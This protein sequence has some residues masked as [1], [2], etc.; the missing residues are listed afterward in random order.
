MLKS[1]KNTLILALSLSLTQV[2]TPNSF[3][4]TKSNETMPGLNISAE[5]LAE[6]K[7]DPKKAESELQTLKNLIPLFQNHIETTKAEL[8]K[9][10]EDHEKQFGKQEADRN[11]KAYISA[12]VFSTLMMSSTFLAIRSS[13]YSYKAYEFDKEYFRAYYENVIQDPELF[14][15]YGAEKLVNLAKQQPIDKM[16]KDFPELADALSKIK[17]FEKATN[18]S[19]LLWVISFI[20]TFHYLSSSETS[21]INLSHTK[22]NKLIYNL[23]QSQSF[24]NTL[25]QQVDQI[26]LVL[27]TQQSINSLN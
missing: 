25:N 12:G 7:K 24:L 11:F 26:Q 16:R 27:K 18:I 8:N 2:Y 14:K 21:P 4:D 23:N 6:A 15:Y 19:V 5:I 20:P 3:A 9:A 1:L 10:Q 17:R 13:R 22:I